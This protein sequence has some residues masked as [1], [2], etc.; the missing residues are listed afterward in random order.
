M[1]RSVE[2]RLSD[3][4]SHTTLLNRRWRFSTQNR[5]NYAILRAMSWELHDLAIIGAGMMGRSIATKAAQEGINVCLKEISMERAEIC[6]EALEDELD[7]S[8]RRFDRTE[9]EKKAILSRIRWVTEFNCAA[10][11]ELA[12][13]TVQEDFDLKRGIVNE[14]DSLMPVEH[15]IVV[16]TSTLSVTE[17]AASCK[18]PERILAM[19][20]LY[21]ATSTR[22]VEVVRGQV[23]TDEVFDCA[24]EFARLLE[25]VPIKVFEMPGFVTTRVVLPLVNEAIHVVMEGVAEPAEVDLAI[26]LGYDFR[27][28]PLEWADR[29]GLDKVLNWLKHLHQESGEPRFRP[30]PLLKRLVRAGLLGTKTGRGFFT[31]DK[32]RRRLDR[33]PDDK[34][35]LA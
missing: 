2:V 5:R 32:N 1:A 27:T 13:E 35:G 25:K 8:I 18:N 10:N 31:Y 3:Y 9:S 21:P 14:L 22:V 30:C 16:N 24:L 20:F 19:H 28:G 23:T 12:I 33:L 4:S 6:R 34:P 11:C 15:P 29:V 7:H 26:K 17:L